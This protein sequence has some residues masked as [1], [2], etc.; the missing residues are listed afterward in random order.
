MDV[1]L[2]FIIGLI[3]SLI[4]A[5]VSGTGL[6]MLPL[7]TILGLSP[8]TAIATYKFGML[9]MKIGS[10]PNYLKAEKIV[11]KHVLSFS[12]L[13]CTGSIIGATILVSIDPSVLT[14]FIGIV[15]LC[16]LPLMT[17]NIG[18]KHQQTSS[19]KI[20]VGYFL[21]FLIS[22]WIGV[23][24]GGSGIMLMYTHTIFFGFTMLEWKGTNKIP[25]LFT[26]IPVFIILAYNGLVNWKYGIILLF[27]MGLG[28]YLG[29]KIA[30]KKGD[31]W[32]RKAFI[33]FIMIASLR[34]II[35]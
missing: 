19:I 34:M 8:Q 33:M 20:S 28:A 5:L 25:R 17:L 7:L 22:I 30:L 24:G 12:I 23:F 15:L 31:A 27:S 26:D 10:F 2:V 18:I 16:I 4:G 32:I 21:Q 29:S 6:V 1:I 14:K 11:W 9:A 35:A 3:G 13:G